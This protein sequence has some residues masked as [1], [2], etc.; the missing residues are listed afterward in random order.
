ML[1][2]VLVLL[3]G[4]EIKHEKRDTVDIN[5]DVATLTHRTES[6]LDDSSHILATT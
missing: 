3:D 5:N 2:Q 6:I 4:Q 1:G